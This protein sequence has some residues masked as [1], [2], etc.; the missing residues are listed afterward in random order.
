MSNQT[1]KV[2]SRFREKEH[3]VSYLRGIPGRQ[4][5]KRVYTSK[6]DFDKYS[7]ELIDRWYPLMDVE[8]YELIEGKWWEIKKE[9][10]HT[11]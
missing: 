7:P 5:K 8:C 1:F 9:N 2:I 10:K 3:Q 11:G 4:H 6:E